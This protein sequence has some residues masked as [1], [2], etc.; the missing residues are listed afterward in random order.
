MATITQREAEQ[1]EQA[2]AG[3][4]TP[5][6]FIHGLWLLPSSWD[7]W[8]GAFEAAG[9]APLAPGWPDDPDTVEA[10]RANPDAFAGKGV[11]QVADHFA[12]VIGGLTRKPAIVGHSFGGLI[13]QILAGRG[14]SVASVA[15]DPA[16]FKGVLPL[17]IAAIRTTLP[18]LSN[19]ANHGRAVTLTL[20]QFRYGWANALS[21]E[22]SK[23]L[24]EQFHVAAP[25]KPIFQAATANFNPGSET[26]VDTENPERGPLLITTGGNDHAV[27][28]A[29]SRAAFK[30]QSRNPGVTEHVELPDRDHSLTIDDGW[31]EVADLAL[32][33]V[34]RFGD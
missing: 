11:A 7:R 4:R 30:K 5:V 3:G 14:L 1:I 18:V 34:K 10:A 9:Y 29:M 24:Y 26:K 15:V 12:E 32:A 25:G 21:D 8:A 27:P 2:N 23:R 16:P 28:P 33:F 20:K 19:P 6:V 13:T 22:E 17:P 31:R